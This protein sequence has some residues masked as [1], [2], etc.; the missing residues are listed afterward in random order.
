MSSLTREAGMVSGLNPQQFSQFARDRRAGVTL[1]ANATPGEIQA[2][3][4]LQM[5][6]SITNSSAVRNLNRSIS[7]FDNTIGQYERRI[8]AGVEERNAGREAFRGNV[9]R[10]GSG[11]GAVIGSIASFKIGDTIAEQMVGYS[12]WA[13]VGVQMLSFVVLQ[14]AGAVIGASI[15]VVLTKSIVGLGVVFASPFFV[16]TAIVAGLI[17]GL[18]YLY[19]N[20]KEALG[21]VT[22]WLGPR[23]E[24]GAPATDFSTLEIPNFLKVEYWS[25]L[26]R[27]AGKAFS[28]WMAEKV[29]WIYKAYIATSNA[30]DA[31]KNFSKNR[32]VGE[33]VSLE[34][35]TF[36]ETKNAQGN[37]PTGAEI[38]KER[39]ALT[40]KFEKYTEAQLVEQTAVSKHFRLGIITILDEVG[41]FAESTTIGRKP[42]SKEVLNYKDSLAKQIFDIDKFPVGSFEAIRSERTSVPLLTDFLAQRAAN[43]GRSA[44]N[45]ANEDRIAGFPERS[46]STSFGISSAFGATLEADSAT[47]LTNKLVN[48][49]IED[50]G[51]Q[52]AGLGQDVR[53]KF[54]ITEFT[55]P[56]LTYPPESTSLAGK[57]VAGAQ[58]LIRSV[59][60]SI[61]GLGKVS[62]E[63]MVSIKEFHE[64]AVRAATETV[65][66]Y[67]DKMNAFGKALPEHVR[68]Q[69]FSDFI[70]RM[71]GTDTY[72]YATNFTNTKIDDLSEHPNKPMTFAYDFVK[73]TW[74]K[75]TQLT[76]DAFQR[77]KN[78]DLVTSA[79]G[80]HQFQRG[81]WE[82]IAGKL[83]LTDF[84]PASQE[85]A[86]KEDLA[87]RGALDEVLA[88]DF[89]KAV[90]ILPKEWASL[91][92]NNSDS[93][94]RGALTKLT[95]LPREIVNS[96]SIS[97]AE[98]APL[99]P[100]TT[101]ESGITGSV[102]NSVT[103]AVS[104]FTSNIFG[105]IKEFADSPSAYIAK[106]K[107]KFTASTTSTKPSDIAAVAKNTDEFFKS[108]NDMM[109]SNSL[110]EFSQTDFNKLKPAEIKELLELLDQL[111]QLSKTEGYLSQQLAESSRTDIR[112]RIAEI[113]EKKK[114]A[115][116]KEEPPEAYGEAS[117]KIG[118]TVAEEGKAGFIK[119][120]VEVLKGKASL[121]DFISKE[122]QSYSDKLLESFVKGFVDTFMKSL[123]DAS[124][125]QAEF[126][127]KLGTRAGSFLRKV[128]GNLLGEKEDVKVNPDINR[129]AEKKLGGFA[130]WLS[131]LFNTKSPDTKTS[132][133]GAAASIRAI[134]NKSLGGTSSDIVSSI[135]TLSST[136]SAESEVTRISNMQ[137]ATDTSTGIIDSILTSGK[138]LLE[139]L[140]GMITKLISGIGGLFSSDSS[141]SGGI[142]GLFGK[143]FDLFKT[144]SSVSTGFTPISFLEP[145]ADGGVVPGLRGTPMPVLA[146]GGEV[147][148]NAAQ[149]GALGSSLMGQSSPSTEQ[150]FNINVTGDVSRQTRST[151][152]QMLPMIASGVNSLNSQRG[153]R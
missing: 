24:D 122:F 123:F 84:G 18:K 26:G 105:Q 3:R 1:D 33:V 96:L 8:A 69:A 102:T 117:K 10:A 127:N 87:G 70:S 79:A 88:G 92:Q 76:E 112:K 7:N 72:G 55:L 125:E 89:G 52:L 15:A 60:N 44:L 68:L 5:A 16:I 50:L 36:S 139:G 81:I 124:G 62:S 2:A 114:P 90:K 94:W 61:Q 107:E 67:A 27:E 128:V 11:V 136:L 99:V 53:D 115:E 32:K 153:Y 13:K 109:K 39:D 58:S 31:V 73:R 59:D 97:K 91:P 140:I 135:D 56:S 103:T 131:D 120:L 28:D 40:K 108:L 145:F 110:E 142:S 42:T 151:I 95:S 146:H 148:L 34:I 57:T 132:P 37:L 75:A 100:T 45:K 46:A 80:K 30:I 78:S 144:D 152:M 54:T 74:V 25:N 85:A 4:R 51:D 49:R 98:T 129:P 126:A 63:A 38:F 133:A 119:G 141:G 64:K 47:R 71:E 149:Q 104:D 83:G 116:P 41:K 17:T 9:I 22:G 137:V 138:S 35:A 6:N 29:P 113:M 86:F 106:M 150:T 65:G 48:K 101:V 21:F 121:T 14:G 147:V 134:D 93:A 19:D 82:K 130:G 77:A 118:K 111:S 43:K 143:F 23:G 12:D 20:S 66:S